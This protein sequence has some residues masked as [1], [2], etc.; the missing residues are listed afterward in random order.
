MGC[1]PFLI[2]TVISPFNW[3]SHS[4][5]VTLKINAAGTYNKIT[6]EIETIVCDIVNPRLSTQ[7]NPSHKVYLVVPVGLLPFGLLTPNS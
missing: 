6:I 2:A 3:T 4:K 5:Q 7:I 1:H